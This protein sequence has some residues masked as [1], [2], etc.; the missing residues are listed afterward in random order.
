M[1]HAEMQAPDV[2]TDL[3]QQIARPANGA[4]WVNSSL[5][6]GVITTLVAGGVAAAL[7]FN[8]PERP[9]PAEHPDQKQEIVP[10]NHLSTTPLPSTGNNR[11]DVPAV[12]RETESIEA[13]ESDQSDG[14]ITI[15]WT[16]RPLYD[17]GNE[18]GINTQTIPQGNGD[19]S[20]DKPVSSVNAGSERLTGYFNHLLNIYLSDTVVCKND[21]CIVSASNMQFF[22]VFWWEMDGEKVHIGDQQFTCRPDRSGKV[23]IALFA[24]KDGILSNTQRYIKVTELSSGAD[25]YI[26]GEKRVRGIVN[27]QDAEKISWH[28]G[29]HSG[30]HESTSNEMDHQ[31]AS[32][33]V[34]SVKTAVMDKNG[35][36]DTAVRHFELL[37]GIEVTNIISPSAKDGKND[38][39]VVEGEDISTYRLTIRNIS[40]TVVYE[41]ENIYDKWDGTDRSTGQLV[42]LGTYIYQITYSQGNGPVKTITGKLNVN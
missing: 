23:V 31:Y 15:E 7:W 1:E 32:Y 29:D 14:N 30:W 22:D 33:G 16:P 37:T 11:M 40:G 18:N 5:F 34:Y 9:V 4:N 19:D 13:G 10:E 41:S 38:F 39:F 35:C 27:V 28:F 17:A 26:L 6:K 12:E 3:S 20:K 8:Q 2:W 42:Q 25:M 36:M 21:R 24:V